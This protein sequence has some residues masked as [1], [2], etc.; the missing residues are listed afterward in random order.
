[1]NPGKIAVIAA[2]AALLVVL[3]EKTST[4]GEYYYDE[5]EMKRWVLGPGGREGN[6]DLCVDNADMG[7]IG[8]DDVF[9]GIDG[10]ID[11]APAHPNCECEVEYKT[12]RTRVYV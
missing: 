8:M 9:D 6:C 10:D 3:H 2:V 11:E 5:E 7:W 12:K 1:M 4:S